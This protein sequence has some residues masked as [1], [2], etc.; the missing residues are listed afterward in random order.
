MTTESDKLEKLKALRGK[1]EGGEGATP[2][3]AQTPAKTNLS[4]VA[5]GSGS[6]RLP[7]LQ[8]GQSVQVVPDRDDQIRRNMDA[9]NEA[10]ARACALNNAHIMLKAY[11]EA[12]TASGAMTGLKEAEVKLWLTAI[13][14]VEYE[15]NLKMLGIRLTDEDNIPF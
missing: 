3:A 8:A 11:Q 2:S 13:K 9:K 4:A 12:C 7:H 6:G 5:V 14:K 10:I 1:K 15:S